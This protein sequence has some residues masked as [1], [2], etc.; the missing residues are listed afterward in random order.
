MIL[1]L[2]LL[3]VALVLLFFLSQ[4]RDRTWQDYRRR[5]RERPRPAGPERPIDPTFQFDEPPGVEEK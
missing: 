5:Q 2:S 1:I 3:A 4:R